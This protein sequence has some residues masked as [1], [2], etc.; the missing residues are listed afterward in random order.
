AARATTVIGLAAT[1]AGGGQ[2][3]IAVDGGRP[4]S[5]HVGLPASTAPVGW[6]AADALERLLA[7]VA[8]AAELRGRGE[9]AV[10]SG[11]PAGRRLAIDTL[12]RITARPAAFADA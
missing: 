2:W 7:C 3:T 1:G 8:T 12:G 4:V 6:M 5:L 10:E 11:D 9:L